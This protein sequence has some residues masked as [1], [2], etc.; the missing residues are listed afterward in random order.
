MLLALCGPPGV[1]KSSIASA[2]L[3]ADTGLAFSLAAT[4]RPP[5]PG[6]SDRVYRFV[7]YEEFEALVSQGE[8]LEHAE[9]LGN[10]YGELRR[11]AEDAL[12]QGKDLLFDTDLAGAK[13][14]A[15]A[16]SQ[17]IATIGLL[18]PSLDELLRRLEH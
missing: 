14:L 13:S 8:L 6:E 2:L 7:S 15:A 11:P 12:E 1:G 16:L 10:L 3:S 5:R 4:T 18:P 17:P 9:R